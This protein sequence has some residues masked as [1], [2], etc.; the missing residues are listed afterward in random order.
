[1]HPWKLNMTLKRFTVCILN[2]GYLI[3][4]LPV[5]I[6]S[7][8]GCTFRW[9]CIVHWFRS[10]D[11]NRWEEDLQCYEKVCAALQISSSFGCLSHLGSCHQSNFISDKKVCQWKS[12]LLKN[13]WNHKITLVKHILSS[14]SLHSGV[15]TFSHL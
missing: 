14:V 11:K 7:Y 13:Y 2:L 4:C 9:A 5:C 1:M 15:I 10:T 6:W 3:V 12:M 8:R